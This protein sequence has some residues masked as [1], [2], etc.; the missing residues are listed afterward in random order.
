MNDK[1]VSPNAP[2]LYTS[3]EFLEE[4]KWQARQ[5]AG[6]LDWAITALPLPM[7]VHANHEA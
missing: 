6:P 7:C 4:Q 3:T 2:F 1:N 5:K